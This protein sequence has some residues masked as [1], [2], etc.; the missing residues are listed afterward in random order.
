M[1]R[2]ARSVCVLAGLCAAATTFAPLARAQAPGTSRSA[3][4]LRVAGGMDLGIGDSFFAGR[5]GLGILGLEWL[6]PRAPFSA[7]LDL[8]YFRR[9]HD[10]GD[11]EALGCTGY[12]RFGE[13]HDI[14]GISLDGRYTFFS[15]ARIRP[16]LA[17]GFGLYRSTI[18]TTTNWR[19]DESNCVITPGERHDLSTSTLGLGLHTGLGFAVP[20]HRSELSLEL[21]LQQLSGQPGGYSRYTVPILFGIRF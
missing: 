11:Q 4:R 5:S 16:F 21:R 3:V 14:L 7:R 20:I 19:C 17:S 6:H 9:E 15:R 2:F 18:T 13:R 10:F 12:C 8:S 1:S